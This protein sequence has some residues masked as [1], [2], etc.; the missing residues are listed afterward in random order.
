MAGSNIRVI[1]EEFLMNFAKSYN[2]LKETGLIPVA[3]R[4]KLLKEFSC[5]KSRYYYYL[6]L[7]R[8]KH[9]V[10]DSYEQN[11]ANR[12]ERERRLREDIHEEVAEPILNSKSTNE[13]VETYIENS[14]A[15]LSHVHV[16]ET[17]TPLVVSETSSSTGAGDV[18]IPVPEKKSF[19]ARLLEKIFNK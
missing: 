18:F 12:I 11:L 1:D 15:D 17:T 5:G 14:T 19:F 4:E 9:Y 16:G 10:T 7:A 13:N 3:I 2:K 6:S 8:E